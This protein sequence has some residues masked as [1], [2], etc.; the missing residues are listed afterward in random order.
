MEKKKRNNGRPSDRPNQLAWSLTVY[1]SVDAF[2]VSLVR[3]FLQLFVIG[4]GPV[5]CFIMGLC[6]ETIFPAGKGG[7]RGTLCGCGAAFSLFIFTS[8]FFE[9]KNLQLFF[10]FPSL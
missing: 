7:E 6:M 2:F 8:F 4:R 5:S 10:L 3:L 1:L 9:E